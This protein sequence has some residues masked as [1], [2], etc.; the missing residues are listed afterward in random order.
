MSL[1]G[2]VDSE[3]VV[4]SEGSH[5]HGTLAFLRKNDTKWAPETLQLSPHL[6]LNV[7]TGCAVQGFGFGNILSRYF[8]IVVVVVLLLVAV[9]VVLIYRLCSAG[10]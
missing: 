7:D 1:V 6:A 2:R 3:Q 4:G 5:F 10:V 9:V 8:C